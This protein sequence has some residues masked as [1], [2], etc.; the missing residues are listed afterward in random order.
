V[1]DRSFRDVNVSEHPLYWRASAISLTKRLDKTDGLKLVA[2][3]VVLGK[4][5]EDRN[6]ARRNVAKRRLLLLETLILPVISTSCFG[7]TTGR[8]VTAE[9]QDRAHDAWNRYPAMCETRRMSHQYDTVRITTMRADVVPHPLDGGGHV[10]RPS[11]P[12]MLRGD[13]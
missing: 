12:L 1:T 10:L 6:D 7:L 5:D 2:R 11:R 3:R 9:E 4:A 8:L 13:R